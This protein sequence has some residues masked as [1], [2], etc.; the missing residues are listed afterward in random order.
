MAEKGGHFSDYYFYFHRTRFP[1]RDSPARGLP[2]P[3][4]GITPQILGAHH[5]AA[6]LGG[7]QPGHCC[8][9]RFPPTRRNGESGAVAGAQPHVPSTA[10]TGAPRGGRRAAPG[11]VATP[12]GHL[13]APPA[14]HLWLAGLGGSLRPL[15][16]R[17]PRWGWRCPVPPQAHPAVVPL[18][19]SAGSPPYLAPRSC[20]NRCSIGAVRV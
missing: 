9:G 2:L 6:L 7:H 13:G 5:E 4:L 14:L 3:R 16:G 20:T 17:P 1:L 11:P 18:V 10:G 19:S 8:L 15:E 12:W